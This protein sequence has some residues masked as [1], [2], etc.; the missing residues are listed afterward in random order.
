MIVD[1]L[2]N[3]GRYEGL[4]A[5]FDVAF[6]FLRS[7]NLASLALG[8]HAIDGDRVFAVVGSAPRLAGRRPGSKPIASTSTSAS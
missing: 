5:G 8:R 7:P 4:H 1:H 3:A 6:K 2:E